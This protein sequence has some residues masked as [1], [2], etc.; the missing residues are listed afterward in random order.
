MM[1]GLD[2]ARITGTWEG[3]PMSQEENELAYHYIDV[4]RDQ[5]NTVALDELLAPNYQRYVFATA[6]KS[7]NSLLVN[8]SRFA[9]SVADS[10]ASKPAHDQMDRRFFQGPIVVPWRKLSQYVETKRQ[11]AHRETD[12]KSVQWLTE[13]IMEREQRSPPIPAYLRERGN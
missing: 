6:P 10:S 4:V 1:P 7:I 11:E 9:S 2:S 3:D 13:R 8:K 12:F 5:K